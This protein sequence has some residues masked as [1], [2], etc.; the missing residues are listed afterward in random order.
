MVI[1]CFEEH[2][3]QG[4]TAQSVQM[5][6]SLVSDDAASPVGGVL[7]RHAGR[8]GGGSSVRTSFSIGS[9]QNVLLC[10]YCTNPINSLHLVT[11]DR[12]NKILVSSHHWGRCDHQKNSLKCQ[13]AG[14][15]HRVLPLSVDSL[16]YFI[17]LLNS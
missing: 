11:C 14:G 5:A 9:I 13:D 1:W 7:S 4:Q 16:K 15:R 8:H 17:E 12:H 6:S 2:V 10:N 3:L